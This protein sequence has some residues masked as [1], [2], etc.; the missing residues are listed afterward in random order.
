MKR[1]LANEGK[2][3]KIALGI[4]LLIVVAAGILFYEFTKCDE[5]S[6]TSNYN[7]GFSLTTNSKLENP[8]FYTPVPVFRNKTMMVNIVNMAIIENERKSD[9][10]NLSIIETEYGKMLKIDA[11]EFVPGKKD[12]NVSMVADHIIDTIN[13]LHPKIWTS[14]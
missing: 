5:S 12:I 9:G 3:L 11:K 4:I 7:F 13:G 10:W 1:V 2:L 14:S 6:P 8:T